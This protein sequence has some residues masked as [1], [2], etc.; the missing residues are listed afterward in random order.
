MIIND[1]CSATEFPPRN[2]LNPSKDEEIKIKTKKK[3]GGQVRDG[4]LVTGG[5]Q[6]FCGV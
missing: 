2:C 3:R 6:I 1:A 5:Q 4:I